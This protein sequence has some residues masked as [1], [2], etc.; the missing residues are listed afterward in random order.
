MSVYKIHLGY[1]INSNKENRKDYYNLRYTLKDY[2][3]KFNSMYINFERNGIVTNRSISFQVN[4]DII[5]DVINKILR[6]YMFAYI[7]KDDDEQKIIYDYSDLIKSRNLN[8][9]RDKYII[10]Y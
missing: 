1:T 10:V 4:E 2:N 8:E 5:F 6:D 3:L 7:I 9:K